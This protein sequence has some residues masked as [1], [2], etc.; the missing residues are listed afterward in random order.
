MTAFFPELHPHTDESAKNGSV[1]AARI[2]I[3][4]VVDHFRFVRYPSMDLGRL[5]AVGNSFGLFRVFF[6]L[7]LCVRMIKEKSHNLLKCFFSYVHRAVNAITRFGPI[8]FTNRDFPRLLFA[9]IAELDIQQI[10]G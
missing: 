3:R 7:W 2:R 5:E 9:A 6:W 4:P 10:S 8:D 1:T